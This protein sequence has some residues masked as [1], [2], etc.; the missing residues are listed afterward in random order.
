MTVSVEDDIEAEDD[1]LVGRT[2]HGRFRILSAL[3]RGGMGTVYR[4]EQEPLGREIAL[5][6][7]SPRHSEDKA[8]EFRRR[9]FLEAATVAK[10]SHPNTVTIFDYGHDEGLY[11][12]AMELL[13]GITLQRA[14]R[15]EGALPVG[16]A[17][18]I[19]KQVCRSLREAHQQGLIHRDVK[20]GNV[21]LIERDEREVVKVLDF[22]LVK[23]LDR[24]DEE[25]TRAGVFM[26][27]PK[28]MS[29]EQ[30]QGEA[31]DARSD[32]YSLGVVLYEM[33]S[34]RAPFVHDNHVHVLMGHVRFAV[35]PMHP[36]AGMAPLPPPLVDTV[37]RCLAKRPEDRFAS[38]D[39]LLAGLSGVARDLALSMPPSVETSLSDEIPLGGSLAPS[40]EHPVVPG[41]PRLP[42]FPSS[43][44]PPLARPQTDDTDIDAAFGSG[45]ARRALIG[46][47][48]VKGLY[49]LG[50]MVVLLIFGIGF[51]L[52]EPALPPLPER[53]LSAGPTVDPSG[54]GAVSPEISPE[55][56]PAVVP[57][58]KPAVE[59]APGPPAAGPD[60]SARATTTRMIL[61]ASSDPPGAM[62]HIAGA[63][64]GPTPAQIELSGEAFAPG[65]DVVITFAL[66]G[67]E[68]TSVT[69]VVPRGHPLRVA[70]PL[71]PRA[72]AAH[73]PERERHRREDAERKSTGS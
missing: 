39:E 41:P 5:K 2:L 15:D 35:P 53:A 4:A 12:I 26:G 7:L 69:R 55:T 54:G 34:G 27:S 29:P 8:A 9:F 50:L 21:M 52:W 65:E 30:I 62:L 57:T 56:S 16:R 33:L 17:L 45:R 63:E 10:L 71:E 72:R 58:A 24:A 36:K 18:P 1:P 43:L 46:D 64:Y 48:S 25:L 61:E 31:V 44:T 70:V 28:Y 60:R 59:P 47:D 38:I 11:F 3:A 32:I 42:S 6:V 68:P 14:L 19:A 20:P 49:A 66:D 40:G 23:D 51:F 37:M 13:E 22:G 67:Y 73:A